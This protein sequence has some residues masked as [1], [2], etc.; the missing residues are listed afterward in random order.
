MRKVILNLAVSLDGF[1]EGP[2]GEYDWCLN[3]QDYGLTEFWE[4][5]DT[6]LI[7]RRSYEL[8]V[9]TNDINMFLT[10][11]RMFVFSDSLPEIT[12][13]QIEV[14]SSASFAADVNSI[15]EQEGKD[16]WMFGGASLVSAFMEHGLI[17][18]FL[19][20]VHPVLLGNGKPL[21]QSIKERTN[22]QF[23]EAI[24]YSSGLVQLRYHLLPKFDLNKVA[25]SDY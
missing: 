9:S 2:N 25:G 7:G 4:S 6:V 5:I 22:L 16:I 23:I 17:D 24:P 12:H 19:L 10:G 21:F 11:K 3:D 14:I 20:S 18:E 1:I 15:K 8:L 13:D